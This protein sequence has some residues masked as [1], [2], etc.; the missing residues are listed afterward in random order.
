MSLVPFRVRKEVVWHLFGS[1][2]KRIML[3]NFFLLHDHDRLTLNARALT[4]FP[5]LYPRSELTKLIDHDNSSHSCP[6]ACHPLVNMF[7]LRYPPY[8]HPDIASKSVEQTRTSCAYFL[9][10]MNISDFFFPS[11]NL[12]FQIFAP[13]LP[14]IK[15]M[16][17]LHRSTYWRLPS[18]HGKQSMSLLWDRHTLIMLLTPFRAQRFGLR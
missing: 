11:L 4:P 6:L 10:V 2:S 13:S 18:S 14:R 16:F 3:I 9:A 15:A 1:S 12:V 5:T 8:N 17:G 7:N